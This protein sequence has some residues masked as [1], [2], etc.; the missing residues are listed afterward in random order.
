MLN[1]LI[2][3]AYGPFRRSLKTAL[4]E[5][6]PSLCLR[7]AGSGPAGLRMALE[8]TPHIICMDIHLPGEDGLEIATQLASLFPQVSLIIITSSDLP[9]Y[10]QAALQAGATHFVSKGDETLSDIQGI[11]RGLIGSPAAGV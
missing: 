6:C 7:E 11:V 4:I 3:D 1:V 5:E 8:D 9:E 10:R 2:I